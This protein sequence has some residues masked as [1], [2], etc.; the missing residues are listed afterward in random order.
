MKVPYLKSA[1]EIMIQVWPLAGPITTGVPS[2][3]GEK[4]IEYRYTVNLPKERVYALFTEL[5]MVGEARLL[6]GRNERLTLEDPTDRT[7]RGQARSLLDD[8]LGETTSRQK[9]W[10]PAPVKK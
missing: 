5:L 6:E 3:L 10:D 1:Q 9:A 2:Q 7:T 4:V 8:F